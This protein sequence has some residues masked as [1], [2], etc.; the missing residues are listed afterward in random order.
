MAKINHD[1]GG[2][3]KLLA[4]AKKGILPQ[5]QPLV[6]HIMGEFAMHENNYDTARA[7]FDKTYHSHY[8]R[9]AEAFIARK[10]YQYAQD[11]A[12]KA[13][14]FERSDAN[15]RLW[16][17]CVYATGKPSYARVVL[18]QTAFPLS[19]YKTEAWEKTE[20]RICDGCETFFLLQED[21]VLCTHCE[22]AFYCSEECLIKSEEVHKHMFCRF[23]CGCGKHIPIGTH[24][25]YCSGCSFSFYCS[26]DCQLNDWN[27]QHKGQCTRKK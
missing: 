11:F 18:K 8:A 9:V 20:Q 22:E 24:R 15:Q 27:I 25:L 14:L 2:A 13:V 10:A 16:A 23:C 4:I 1:R 7:F 21:T 19:I 5:D 12:Y 6:A 3:Y 26:T 17:M